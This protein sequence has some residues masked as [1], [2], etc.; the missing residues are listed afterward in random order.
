MRPGW[1]RQG[2]AM[3]STANGAVSDH[4]APL[5]YGG[6]KLVQTALLAASASDGPAFARAMNDLGGGAPFERMFGA[7]HERVAA[8]A[9]ARALQA[10][11]EALREWVDRFDVPPVEVDNALSL[12]DRIGRE[13]FD[14]AARRLTPMADAERG[15]LALAGGL[16][17]AWPQL[18]DDV[19]ARDICRTLVHASLRAAAQ[20]AEALRTPAAPAD[21]PVD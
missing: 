20:H 13:D 18:Y 4:G 2:Q 19:V 14:R 10:T 21:A 8:R 16:M 5:G 3:G 1:E 6:E 17:R 7:D 11:S 12:L 9:L 15:A